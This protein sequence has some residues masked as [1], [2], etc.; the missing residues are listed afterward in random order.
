MKK[1]PWPW[2]LMLLYMT[3]QTIVGVLGLYDPSPSLYALD[4]VDLYSVLSVIF[5][6]LGVLGLF[7]NPKV[8]MWALYG[9]ALGT[10]IHGASI[11]LL[12][13]GSLQ[14]GVR[15]VIAPLM[16]VPMAHIWWK[17]TVL[18]TVLNRKDKA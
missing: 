11:M 5:A 6:V 14:T 7:R 12:P 4:L 16:M 2:W 9:M 13:S 17:Y 8:V 1:R 18:E 3:G 15:L 10:M